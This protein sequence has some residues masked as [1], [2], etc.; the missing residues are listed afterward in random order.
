MRDDRASHL[1]R[2]RRAT[3]YPSLFRLAL[4]ALSLVACAGCNALRIGG[5]GIALPPGNVERGKT[6]FRDLQCYACH[7]VSGHDFPHPDVQPPVL[8]VLGTEGRAPSR[9]ELVNSIINPSHKIYP[10]FDRKLV[11]TNNVS[12]MSDFSEIITVRQLC[13]LVAF[14][15]TLHR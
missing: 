1:T 4:V 6:A 13:D 14:L 10:G 8:V 15:E 3:R 5:A 2:E 11:Q 12:R 9:Q 7:S